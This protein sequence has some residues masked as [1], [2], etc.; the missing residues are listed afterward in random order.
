VIPLLQE[1][2]EASQQAEVTAEV[3]VGVG[4]LDRPQS[5]N[6]ERLW[7]CFSMIY[8]PSSI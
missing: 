4:H 8:R 6:A 7:S 1:V 5:G 2:V 3:L